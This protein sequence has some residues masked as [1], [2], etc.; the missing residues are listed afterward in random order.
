MSHFTKCFRSGNTLRI[1]FTAALRRALC[2]LPADI[3]IFRPGAEGNAM[4]ENV[5]HTERMRRLRLKK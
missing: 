5:S 3:L 4:V 2:A 1:S